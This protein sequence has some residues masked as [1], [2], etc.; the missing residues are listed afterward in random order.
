MRKVDFT[1][2]IV[3]SVGN[4]TRRLPWIELPSDQGVLKRLLLLLC[5]LYVVE[6]HTLLAL[7]PRQSK[8]PTPMRQL[9]LGGR[10]VEFKVV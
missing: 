6:E 4:A 10:H 1:I 2:A 8:S 3:V 9:R 7:I 5:R